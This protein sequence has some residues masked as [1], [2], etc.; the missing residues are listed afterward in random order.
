MIF[1]TPR[2]IRN[3]IGNVE[4]SE[5]SEETAGAPEAK[6]VEAAPAQAPAA[7]PAAAPAPAQE[8][9]PAEPAA[10]P[11]APAPEAPAEGDWN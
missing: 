10:A 6:K 7:A 9:A 1:V 4:L 8:A 2:I 3:Y 11:E 5:P